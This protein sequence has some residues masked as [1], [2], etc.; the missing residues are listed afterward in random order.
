MSEKE[1]RL[2]DIKTENAIW[3]VYIG[4]II[5][6]WYANSKEKHFVLYKDDKSKKEYHIISKL[7][8]LNITGFICILHSINDYNTK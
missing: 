1:E 3:V 2:K 6:S 4:I 7:P 5:L 8:I